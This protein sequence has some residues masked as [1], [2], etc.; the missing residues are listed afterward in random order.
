MRS[1][2]A[3]ATSRRHPGSCSGSPLSR[4]S[5]RDEPPSPWPSRSVTPK[6][7]ASVRRAVNSHSHA[8]SLCAIGQVSVRRARGLLSGKDYLPAKRCAAR[9]P[10]AMRQRRIRRAQSYHWFGQTP[11]R[12]L[13][14]QPTAILVTSSGSPRISWRPDQHQR[15]I[16]AVDWVLVR[17]C[18][19]RNCRKR[20][21]AVV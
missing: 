6:C 1:S 17:A 18:G 3:A 10:E 12:R 2:L 5:R 19:S 9:I 4:V 7:A 11:S 20:F 21:N 8:E 15:A 16:L 13:Q 14:T